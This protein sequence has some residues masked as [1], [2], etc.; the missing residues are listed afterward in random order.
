MC[1]QYFL[2]FTGLAGERVLKKI[3]CVD[4]QNLHFRAPANRRQREAQLG[5]GG[6]TPHNENPSLSA[7]GNKVNRNL[8]HLI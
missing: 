5:P 6:I 1:R 3:Y 2:Y 7:L 8:D 4:F